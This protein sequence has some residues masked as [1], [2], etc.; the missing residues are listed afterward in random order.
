MTAAQHISYALTEEAPLFAGYIAKGGLP[1]LFGEWALAGDRPAIQQNFS[2]TLL[3][4]PYICFTVMVDSFM[5][6][7][8]G[9]V[10][11]LLPLCSCTCE[12]HKMVA[13]CVPLLLL[14]YAVWASYMR[15]TA[16]M[17]AAGIPY[18]SVD[19]VFLQQ[20]Q[21]FYDAQAA[22]YLQPGSAGWC[23]LTYP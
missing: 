15:R 16:P 9:K 2:L 5:G 22:A 10:R 13:P 8:P 17:L 4:D 12:D 19:D 11:E 1:P 18:G 23:D 7:H 21:G 14:L 20:I 3:V 6:R